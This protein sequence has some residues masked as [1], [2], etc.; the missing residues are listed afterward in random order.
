MI[1]KAKP[2]D[3]TT[4]QNIGITTFTDTFGGTCTKA[5][6]QEVL[7]RY[8]NYNQCKSEL[9]NEHDHFFFYEEQELVKGYMRINNLQPC[10]LNNYSTLSC[11][12]LVRLYVLKA[13]H[14]TGVADA[15][16]QYAVNFAKQKGHKL[17]YL[18]V[19]EYNFRA[20]G[21]YEKH[22]FSNT[23]IQ[24]PF[25]LGTTAQTDYWFVKPL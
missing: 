12:E 2:N 22:G 15:L 7:T 9:E 18:S 11:I 5:D 17:L 8:F 21:F 20:R 13:Y 25:P 6:L 16:M 3:V 23:G 4:L 14:G 24:H 1:R 10:P 19:W